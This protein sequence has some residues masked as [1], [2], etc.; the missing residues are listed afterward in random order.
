MTRTFRSCPFKRSACRIPLQ[1]LALLT[2]TLL[3]CG[4]LTSCGGGG[5]TSGGGGG[6]TVATPFVLLVSPAPLGLV[7]NSVVTVTFKPV[8]ASGPTTVTMS[9]LPSGLTTDATFPLQISGASASVTFRAASSLAVGSFN[10]NFTAQSGSATTLTTLP[11]SVTNTPAPAFLQSPFFVEVGVSIP[12]SGQVQVQSISNAPPNGPVTDFDIALSVSGLPPGTTAT[13]TP[14]TIVPGQA[15]TLVITA[16]SGAPVSRNV[17]LTVTGTPQAPVPPSSFKLLLDVTQPPGSLPNNRT[18]YL[19]LEGSPNSAVYDK[20]HNLIFASNPSWNRVAVISNQTHAMVKSIPVPDSRSVDISPDGSRVWVGTGG[21]Q[22]YEINTSTL[23][24]VRHPLPPVSFNGG[25]PIAWQDFQILSLVDGTLM[26]EIRGGPVSLSAFIW[27]P[28]TNAVTPLTSPTLGSF[29]IMQRTGDGKRVYC[30]PGDSGGLAFF[31]DVINKTFSTPVDIGGQPFTGSVNF[32]GS[33]VVAGLAMFDGDFNFLGN[34]PPDGPVDMGGPEFAGGTIFSQ[35]TGLLYEVSTPDDLTPEI[36]AIDPNTLTVLS[37][38]PAMPMIPDGDELG[39]LFFLPIPFAVDSTGMVLGLEDYG[40]SFDDSTAT[41]IFSLPQ[42]GTPTFMQHMTPQVGPLAGGTT[43]GGFGNSFSLTP[44]V[45]YGANRGVAHLNAANLVTITSPSGN[46]P[47]PVN[48]K[49]LFPDGIEVFDPLFFSYGPFVQ[50]S[51]QSGAGPSGGSTG[52]IAGYGLPATASAGTVT[53]GGAPATITSSTP[54]IQSLE[55]ASYPFPAGTVNFT[56]PPGTPGSVA[57]ITVTTPDGSTTFTKGIYYAASVADFASADSFNAIL[58]DGKRQQLYLSSGDHIDVFSLAAGR[59]VA[60]LTPPA[61]GALKEF[62]GMA[63]TPDGNTLLAADL[64]DGSLAVINPDNPSASSFI[65]VVLPTSAFRCTLGPLFVAAG[66][67]NK[68]YVTQG[69]LPPTGCSTSGGMFQV[70]LVAGTS[71]IVANQICG[72]D[73]PAGT[74][75]SSSA[76]GD[77]VAFNT[78]IFDAVGQSFNGFGRNELDLATISADGNVAAGFSAFPRVAFTDT[79]GNIISRVAPSDVYYGFVRTQT[80]PVD[81]RIEPKLNDSGSLFYQPWP[82]F[83]DIVDVLHGSLKMR[84]SL[85]GQT[86]S[87]TGVPM[88]ID[89]GGR[90]IYLLTDRG[91]TIVDLGK[92]PLAVGSLSIAAGGPGTQITVRGSGFD[93]QTTATLGNQTALVSF[94][95]ENTL[96]IT[97]PL[98]SSGIADLTLNRSDG[99]SYTLENAVAIP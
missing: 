27:D 42:P 53:V 45:W 79:T 78:C 9:G 44:D 85:P 52:Q 35:D 72:Q 95:D 88:A 81:F 19:S 89:S 7:P 55:F 98:T 97:I 73:L 50:S 93:P 41:V 17:S 80:D 43:S 38:A 86:I 74:F 75:V 21:H 77:H 33:R 8:G 46:A 87:D 58:F 23:T 57:D 59:F 84:F 65:P 5:S 29:D 3:A 66:I 69:G 67:N 96:T 83:F 56:V 54:R 91:L 48:V 64:L 22:V 68:A 71:V 26:F 40:I 70:D 6:G 16:S 15:S 28:V 49:I 1:A 25:G 34:L 51:V 36:L 10:I 99:A 82:Q 14:A 63:L 11:V 31:Y 60:P 62:A 37:V 24:A 20:A 76:A 12:G 32:D 61:S 2:I 18:D 4:S 13:F 47:G 39:H 94:V 30:F 92:A 90:H